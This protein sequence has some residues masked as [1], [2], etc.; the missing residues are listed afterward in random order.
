MTSCA[1][2]SLPRLSFS[3]TSKKASVPS[4]NGTV[5]RVSIRTYITVAYH[6]RVEIHSPRTSL[7]FQSAAAAISIT[8][9][10]LIRLPAAG[11]CK[12]GRFQYRSTAQRLFGR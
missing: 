5:Y 7:L 12:A 10:A 9:T 4:L 6:R 1:T 8:L 2:W 3:E 11:V